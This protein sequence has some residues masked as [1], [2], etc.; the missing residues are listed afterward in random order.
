MWQE[1]LRHL[2]QIQQERVLQRVQTLRERY[3]PLVGSDD[4]H[5]LHVRAEQFL[6][7]RESANFREDRCTRVGE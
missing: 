5:Q 3:V 2:H 7:Q 6:S 4:L 1:H